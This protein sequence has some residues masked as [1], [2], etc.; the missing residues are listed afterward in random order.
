MLGF[1][2]TA[3]GSASAL[4]GGERYLSIFKQNDPARGFRL[5]EGN[6]RSLFCVDRGRR[7]L[8]NSTLLCPLAPSAVR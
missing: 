8:M 1:V 4:P 7:L 3:Q 6:E 2:M 5:L